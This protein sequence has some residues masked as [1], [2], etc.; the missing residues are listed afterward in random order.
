MHMAS[1]AT[2]AV[3]LGERSGTPET[4]KDLSKNVFLSLFWK[5]FEE[6][7]EFL[8]FQSF[9]LIFAPKALPS[10]W[11]LCFLPQRILR[12]KTARGTD[13]NSIANSTTTTNKININ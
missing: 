1:A 9:M 6:P 4:S 7:R 5:V 12:F 8:R 3:C 13:H 11:F 2:P 10:H